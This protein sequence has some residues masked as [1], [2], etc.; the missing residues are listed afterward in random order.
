M[1]S[2]VEQLRSEGEDAL[3]AARATEAFVRRVIGF[4]I[5]T[6]PFV[7][8][9]LQIYLSL[10]RLGTRAEENIRP[11]VFLT[12]AL[13]GWTERDQVALSFPELQEEHDAAQ[14]VKIGERI[15]VVLGNPPY[16]RFVG[17]P[18]KEESDL[19][20]HYK[21]IVRDEKGRQVGQSRLYSEWKIRKHLLD[22]LYIRFFR[23]AE[24]SIGERAAF[25]VV[26]FI[27]NS[28]YL[29]GRS[30]P[31]MRESI[32][33]NFDAMWID[34]LHGNRLAS[35]RTPWGGSCETIF[36]MHGMGGGPGIKV[37]TA[38]ST[39]VKRMGHRR[40]GI[41]KVFIRDFWGDATKKRE[42][43]L[44]SLSLPDWDAERRDK[45]AKRPAGPRQ[46]EE[47]TPTKEKRW[48]LVLSDEATVGYDSW[49]ALDELFPTS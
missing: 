17:V 35:E 18:V 11:A 32:L 2:I 29:V 28:S 41:A 24:K 9:Q 23:I 31:L 12:N 14:R 22:D 19:V 43:L 49:L 30:H 7:I 4:E 13:T 10:I 37:G 44:E 38:V 1:R 16:N 39:L 15:I 33:R 36:N 48:R 6:A 21:G 42:A 8:A 34:N 40:N 46:Y 47:F 5:L 27:S 20:D 3:V 26:S 45:A 25:G